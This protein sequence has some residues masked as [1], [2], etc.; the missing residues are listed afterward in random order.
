LLKKKG[1]LEGAIVLMW[2][3]ELKLINLGEKT[4]HN[5]LSRYDAQYLVSAF[6][7]RA[8][9]LGEHCKKTLAT[10]GKT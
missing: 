9:E 3:Y 1:E 4:M 2:L 7:G 8:E 6:T 5:E 10:M